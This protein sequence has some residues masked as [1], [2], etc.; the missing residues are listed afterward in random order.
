M[1]EDITPARGLCNAQRLPAGALGAAAGLVLAAVV[2]GLRHG[3][4]GLG[5]PG[6]RDPAAAATALVHAA[7]HAL[8]FEVP[9]LAFAALVLPWVARYVQ[10]LSRRTA[11]ARTYTG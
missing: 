8:V 11:E 9:A 7:P 4:I 2:H 10:Q 1:R 5:I 3:L 6:S